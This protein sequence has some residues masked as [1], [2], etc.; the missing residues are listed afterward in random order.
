MARYYLVSVL[1]ISDLDTSDKEEELVNE[2]LSEFDSIGE[3]KEA[4]NDFIKSNDWTG[5][6]GNEG[7][8]ERERE[9][10]IEGCIDHTGSTSESPVDEF[11]E[12][13]YREAVPAGFAVL[14]DGKV[15]N[16][17]LPEH[18]RNKFKN[19][20]EVWVVFDS[21]EKAKKVADW[22]KRKGIFKDVKVL[23]PKDQDRRGASLKDWSFDEKKALGF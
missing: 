12:S 16:W 20:S 10:A 1:G 15:W 17:A 13:I 11:F 18:T 5:S 6:L 4:L 14:A 8:G 21:E 23:T 9:L 3:L 22:L 7:S 2:A 19:K